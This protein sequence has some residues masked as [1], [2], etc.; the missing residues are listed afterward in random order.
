MIRRPPR[1]TLFPYTTLFRSTPGF[2]RSGCAP[3]GRRRLG[4]VVG[5]EENGREAGALVV[6]PAAVAVRG[7]AAETIGRIESVRKARAGQA[8]NEAA[9]EAGLQDPGEASCKD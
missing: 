7:A 2:A 9:A 5:R 1:S 4:E 8:R 3:G 6:A